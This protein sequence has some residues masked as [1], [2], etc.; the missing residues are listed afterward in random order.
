MDSFGGRALAAVLFDLDGTLVDSTAAVVRSWARWAQEEG[1]DP[2]ALNGSHGRP[3]AEIAAS[4]LPA[5]RVTAAV[6]RIEAIEL[7]DTGGVAPLPGAVAALVAL[8]DGRAAV[9]T[10][11]TR[12]LAAAR[13]GAAGLAA[14]RVVVTVDDVTRGKPAPDPFLLAAERLGVDPTRCLV[15]E[16]APAGLAGARA[17]GCATLAVTT[18][19]GP[20]ELEADVVVATLADVVLA[21]TGAGVEVRLA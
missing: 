15:V 12:P 3:A 16:D 7:A 14:P 11:C 4:V 9:A 2:R 18:T 13:I 10:S 17:A 8:P 6:A 21:A 19:H 1:V 20:D 5:G